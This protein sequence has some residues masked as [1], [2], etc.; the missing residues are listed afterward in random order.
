[1]TTLYIIKHVQA[2]YY[3]YHP[4]IN[5]KTTQLFR[6]LYILIIKVLYK[7]QVD[8][9]KIGR[10][11]AEHVVPSR[12]PV[13]TV[14]DSPLCPVRVHHCAQSVCTTVPSQ[15]APL[16]PVRTYHWP[17]QKCATGKMLNCIFCSKCDRIPRVF[18]LCYKSYGAYQ[19]TECIGIALGLQQGSQIV[20]FISDWE[21][22]IADLRRKDNL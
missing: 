10:V 9:I 17:S 21:M 8:W 22:V 18:S 13:C 11:I 14:R 5:L 6:K 20:T 19:G 12:T 15:C 3:V 2:L 7:F 4:H 16:D 1:M